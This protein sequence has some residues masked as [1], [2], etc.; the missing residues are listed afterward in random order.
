VSGTPAP[1]DV[2]AVV[3]TYRPDGAFAGRVA[4][5]AGQAGLVVVVD[6]GASAEQV[7]RLDAW[8]RGHPNVVVVHHSVNRGVAAALNT[9]V[10][11]GM[12]KGFG[13]MLTFDDDSVVA[14]DMVQRL[15]DHLGRASNGRPVGL[16]GMSFSLL[17]T[18]EPEATRP[19]VKPAYFDKRHLITSGTLFHASSYERIGPFR[20]EFFID[21]VDYDYCLRARAKGLRVV[22]TDDIGF[23]HRIGEPA[24][25]DVLGIPVRVSRH[26]A[27]RVYYWF[28]NSLVLALEYLW[29]D[30]LFACAIVVAHVKML[31]SVLWFGPDRRLQLRAAF[32][33]IVDGGLKRLGEQR[34]S[35]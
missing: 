24:V 3:T 5:I 35:R 1:A 29:T 22:K 34:S 23:A 27:A 7:R 9:G 28:R 25:G 18:D 30:P 26:S 2:C 32:R 17:D 15:L 19:C 33:G 14:A 21:W 10:R 13:W 20:E 16:M 31:W 8:F 6:D 4:R 12:R 11:I